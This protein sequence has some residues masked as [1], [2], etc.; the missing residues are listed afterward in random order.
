MDKPTII[1]DYPVAEYAET[2]LLSFDVALGRGNQGHIGMPLRAV[3]EI[4]AKNYVGKSSLANFLAA[5]IRPNGVIWV[6]PFEDVDRDF[7][8]Y[9]T[10]AAGFT[11]TVRVA[12]L[13]DKKGKNRSHEDMLEDVTEALLEDETQA[14]IIDSV[15]A[16]MPNV[17]ST[18]SDFTSTFMG[19]RAQMMA[20]FMRRS[21][22]NLKNAATPKAVFIVNHDRSVI[23][24]MVGGRTTSGG[25]AIK[26]LA[27]VR[28]HLWTKRVIK[29]GDDITGTVIEG[30]VEK[31]KFGPKGRQFRVFLLPGYGISRDMT[32]VIDL[33]EM[34]IA[35]ST[36]KSIHIGDKSIGPLN[37]V[38]A[39]AYA[40]DHNPATFGPVWDAIERYREDHRFDLLEIKG[41]EGGEEIIDGGDDE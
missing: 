36:S 4:Y 3:Y 1:S 41:A 26:D 2:G 32:A 38:I 30:K 6:A 9:T 15:T 7:L 22:Y 16:A 39:A 24:G 13:R 29:K 27:N 18:A 34:G 23:G 37:K 40:P 10:L 28:I 31:L 8:E 19:R 17:E 20:R 14:V 35:K 11:G 25:E 21:P 5:S 12:D 33:I